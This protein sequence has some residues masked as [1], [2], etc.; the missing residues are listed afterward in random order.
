MLG[1]EDHDEMTVNYLEEFVLVAAAK[2]P[3]HFS[4]S[5]YRRANVGSGSFC[6]FGWF[7]PQLQAFSSHV[8]RD[9]YP[10]EDLKMLFRSLELCTALSFL[11]LCPENSGHWILSHFSDCQLHF[12]N[13][14]T[15][16]NC[17]D[18]LSLWRGLEMFLRQSAGG[19]LGLTSFLS[20]LSR[21]SQCCATH[22]P[23]SESIASHREPVFSVVSCGRV[24]SVHVTPYWSKTEV[25]WILFVIL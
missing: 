7:F 22:S 14:E 18:P 10:A 21:G 8:G 24:N 3:S 16:W 13:W 9:Q 6:F 1:I 25:P 2:E 11:Q 5:S 12:L 23:M 19:I 4:D 15:I 20:P 17:L